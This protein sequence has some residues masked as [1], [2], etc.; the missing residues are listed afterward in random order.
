LIAEDGGFFSNIQHPQEHIIQNAC[1]YLLSKY[2][3]E[4]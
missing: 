2:L 4:T 1:D 3:G